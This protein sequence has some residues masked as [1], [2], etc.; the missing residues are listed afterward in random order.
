[1]SI[2]RTF[3]SAASRPFFIPPIEG[4]NGSNYWEKIEQLS[5]PAQGLWSLWM[6]NEATEVYA[7][8]AEASPFYN[9]T[10]I[11]S[12]ATG[13]WELVSP[14]LETLTL[15]EQ[16]A[17]GNKISK[18]GRRSFGYQSVGLPSALQ[19]FIVEN[20]N[21]VWTSYG[22][23]ESSLYGQ[24][25]DHAISSDGN[26]T[27][28]TAVRSGRRWS[29]L[30]KFENSSWVRKLFF[31][32]VY[33]DY[34]NYNVPIYYLNGDGSRFGIG[35]NNESGATTHI[36]QHVILQGG[37]DSF[38]KLGNPITFQT[39]GVL[40]SL[41][42]NDEGNRVAGII[43]QGAYENN[44]YV[45]VWEFDGTSWNILGTPIN[46]GGL[47]GVSSTYASLQIDG[48]WFSYD[49]NRFIGRQM[50]GPSNNTRAVQAYKW[51]GSSW[52]TMGQ[53]IKGNA[54]NYNFGARVWFNNN[55]TKFVV[56]GG[57]DPTEQSAEIWRYIS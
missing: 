29:L 38:P 13:Q 25:I 17:V 6:N 7:S 57:K 37:V 49:G 34:P 2:L 18:D 3:S 44:Y 41:L 47:D 36:Y 45:E 50:A 12:K 9:R 24:T 5:S 55:A 54:A 48:R 33:T 39:N 11:F 15:G 43:G 19:F 8:G 52:V 10:R 1:M 28:H 22:I 23:D 21:G 35:G 53:Q 46:T 32:D 4:V 56:S 51:N 30:H 40:K 20:N 27:F 16:V 26:A 14:N 42:L 31:T